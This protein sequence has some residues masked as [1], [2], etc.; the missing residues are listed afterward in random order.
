MKDWVAENE[1]EKKMSIAECRV[2]TQKHIERVRYYIRFI[3]DRL[4]TRGVKHDAIKLESPEIEVFAE[5]TKY[6]ANMKYDSP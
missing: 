2:E 6:L 5:H 3:T 4:T 1:Q